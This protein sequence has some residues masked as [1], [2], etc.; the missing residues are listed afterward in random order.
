VKK[1]VFALVLFLV[2]AVLVVP[3]C[4]SS[5]AN[6]ASQSTTT[7]LD[8]KSQI[9]STAT[10]ITWEELMAGA[11]KEKVFKVTGTLEEQAVGGDGTGLMS[12][13]G[14]S[15][16]LLVFTPAVKFEDAGLVSM[17]DFSPGEVT[18]YGTV[19]GEPGIDTGGGPE[20]VRMFYVGVV[21]R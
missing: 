15:D 14:N 19:S 3:G 12:V 5:S 4:R 16:H 2:L 7:E 10:A 6:S 8:L 20:M 13:E 17:E 18:F 1:A 21:E 11:P 9:I